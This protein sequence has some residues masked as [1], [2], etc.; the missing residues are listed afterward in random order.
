M[1]KL[2]NSAQNSKDLVLL[3]WKTFNSEKANWNRPS[4]RKILWSL[5][6]YLSSDGRAASC[7]EL[8]LEGIIIPFPFREGMLMVPQC[9][10]RRLGFSPTQLAVGLVGVYTLPMLLRSHNEDCDRVYPAQPCTQIRRGLK[11]GKTR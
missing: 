2:K 3:N 9:G 8:D 7:F 5:F 10:Q 11:G 4:A 1:V 6:P